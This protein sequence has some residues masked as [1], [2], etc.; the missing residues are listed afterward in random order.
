M[1]TV[2]NRVIPKSFRVALR[3]SNFLGLSPIRYSQSSGNFE[4][5]LKS[6][7]TVTCAIVC[8]I[9]IL[10]ILQYGS[11]FVLGRPLAT[12]RW[13]NKFVRVAQGE[14]SNGCNFCVIMLPAF[15]HQLIV[16]SKPCG[17]EKK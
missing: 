1:G 5:K 6:R 11:D 7:A 15:K 9:R 16:R 4:F 17:R 3:I 2:S 8:V 14:V 12:V 10:L 13:V